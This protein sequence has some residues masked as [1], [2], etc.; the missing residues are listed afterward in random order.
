MA[1]SNFSIVPEKDIIIAL[2]VNFS[3]EDL[4]ERAW[5]LF[6][7]LRM[8]RKEAEVKVVDPKQCKLQV[9]YFMV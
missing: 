4:L 6:S 7:L 2:L 3:C 5:L 1:K 8:D 9:K